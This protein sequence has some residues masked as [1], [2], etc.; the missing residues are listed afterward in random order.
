M[1]VKAY[2]G[3]CPLCCGDIKTR[4][5]GGR[6]A[7]VCAFCGELQLKDDGVTA[8]FPLFRQVNAAA[9]EGRRARTPGIEKVIPLFE[10]SRR[11]PMDEA[12]RH[13]V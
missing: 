10:P 8:V 11:R 13:A 7:T 5:N 2:G 12:S 1:R 9:D 4:R 3:T 6:A